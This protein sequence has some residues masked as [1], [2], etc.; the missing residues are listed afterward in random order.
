MSAG[1][2]ASYASAHSMLHKR[3]KTLQIQV[4]S[5]WSPFEQI[6]YVFLPPPLSPLPLPESSQKD[7]GETMYSVPAFPG[8]WQVPSARQNSQRKCPR[9]YPCPAKFPAQVPPS[10][11]VATRN[12]A[13]TSRGRQPADRAA[14]RTA[15]GS[16]KMEEP[17]RRR[18]SSGTAASAVPQLYS[19]DHEALRMAKGSLRGFLVE[20]TWAFHGSCKGG[21]SQESVWAK[22]SMPSCDGPTWSTTGK[23][24]A[25]HWSP[26]R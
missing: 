11:P 24:L 6:H 25:T 15:S 3:K 2:N 22:F 20:E 19:K 13:Q 14:S 26:P 12:S 4:L 18:C 23:R 17:R 9:H 10:L 1:D 7:T 16:P 21:S 8:S 5:A